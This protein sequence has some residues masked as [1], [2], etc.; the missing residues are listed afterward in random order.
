M[1]KLYNEL[2]LEQRYLDYEENVVTDLRKMIARVDEG[3]GL[4]K[5]VFASYLAKIYKRSK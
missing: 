5:E 2:Q 4:K 1:K 3:E